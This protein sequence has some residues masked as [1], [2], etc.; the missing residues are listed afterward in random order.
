MI[1]SDGEVL[2]LLLSWAEGVFGYL[3]DENVD[4]IL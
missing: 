3:F 1:F 2:K 4:G